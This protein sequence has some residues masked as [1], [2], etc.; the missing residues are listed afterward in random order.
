MSILIHNMEAAN[1]QRIYKGNTRRKEKL[2]ERLASG[3]KINRAA[4]NAAGLTISE[5]MRSQI[6]GLDQGAHNLQDGMSLLNVA[7]GALAEVQEML[8]RMTELTV[9]AA[10]DTNTFEDREVIQDEIN[11]LMEEIDRIGT[12]TEFNTIPLFNAEPTEVIKIDKSLVSSPSA[13]SGYL[14]EATK[15]GSRY[16]PSASLDF[17]T[18]NKDNISM[19]YDKTFSFN[20][21][22]S[23][24]EVFQFTLINK[25]G[26]GS[27][28]TG[29]DNGRGTHHYF[30]DINGLRNG[31]QILDRMYNYIHDNMPN[32]ISPAA[33]HLEV[34]HSN[35]LYVNGS[36][37]NI[38]ADTG[39]ATEAEAL[40]KFKN[41]KSPYGGIDLAEITGSYSTN[42]E[43]TVLHIQAG[44]N[45]DQS[46]S[47]ELH[48][49]NSHIIGVDKVNVY[50]Y[51]N[52]TASLTTIHNAVEKI[53]DMRSEFGAEF[54]RMEHSYNNNLNASENLASSESR[55]RDANIADTMVEFSRDSI[56][57][58][59]GEAMI[60]QANQNQ[61]GVI[62]LL[63]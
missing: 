51:E 62:K 43:K 40:N 9:Q 32:G 16:Y 56:L 26:N 31:T 58:Q 38:V 6:R 24:A 47:F 23:C 20:C 30:I 33:D 5:G 10:N 39:F 12:D 44:A 13:E 4:D 60:T 17:S 25:D 50:S 37:M 1:A 53:S 28:V 29:K 57:M 11:M 46:I 63:Q 41:S 54:N 49:M 35:D 15:I 18:I 61:Q 45:T 2:S 21:S 36:K 52:A 22:Q 27:Y 34:S 42:L 55:I 8:H 48:K 14:S 7:D 19:L 59:V 3:F